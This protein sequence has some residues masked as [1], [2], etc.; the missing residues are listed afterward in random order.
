MI[1]PHVPY[2]SVP[3]SDDFVEMDANEICMRK[4]REHLQQ[5]HRSPSAYKKNLIQRQDP[6][7]SYAQVMA[8]LANWVGASGSGGAGD[9]CD[10][11][12]D[13]DLN[14]DAE[15]TPPQPPSDKVEASGSAGQTTTMNSI[16][17][18]QSSYS[19]QGAASG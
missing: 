10:N 16:P 8:S 9:S 18:S 19:I 5:V 6:G 14:N 11:D 3:E 1:P 2:I 13:D 7:L 15:Q 4:V 12:D 17:G